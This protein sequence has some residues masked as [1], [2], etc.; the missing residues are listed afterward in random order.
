MLEHLVGVHVD[1]ERNPGTSKAAREVEE[2]L[3]EGRAE[4][5]LHEH[6]VAMAIPHLRAQAL[7]GAHDLPS[8]AASRNRRASSAMVV[9]TRLASIPEA[10][11]FASR[12]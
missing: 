2:R 5:R 10:V 8:G 4:G 12:T 1:G 3:A 11:M 7:R 6:M 9:S